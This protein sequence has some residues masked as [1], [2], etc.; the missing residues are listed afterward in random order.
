MLQK[1]SEQNK[2]TPGIIVGFD[3]MAFS[4]M[5]SGN[6]DTVGPAADSVKNHFDGHPPRAWNSDDSDIGRILKPADTGQVRSPVAAPVT[7]KGDDSGFKT[8]HVHD[9]VYQSYL[10]QNP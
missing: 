7:Q 1:F 8:V 3:V 9:S 10:Y 6:P 2:F 5:A 4:G